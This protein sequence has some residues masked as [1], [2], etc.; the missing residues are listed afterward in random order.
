MGARTETESAP[1]VFS[2]A[3]EPSPWKTPPASPVDVCTDEKLYSGRWDWCGVKARTDVHIDNEKAKAMVEKLADFELQDACD[4]AFALGKQEIETLKHGLVM[5]RVRPHPEVVDTLMQHSFESGELRYDGI[6][7][8]GETSAGG[9]DTLESARKHIFEN[10][11][12]CMETA[13]MSTPEAKALAK[14]IIEEKKNVGYG[15][16]GQYY[17]QS[18]ALVKRTLIDPPVDETDTQTRA[19]GKFRASLEEHI[20]KFERADLK[21]MSKIGHIAESLDTQASL[22][23]KVIALSEKGKSLA[24]QMTKNSNEMTQVANQMHQATLQTRELHDLETEEQTTMRLQVAAMPLK[25]VR[26]ILNENRLKSWGKPD[27]LR[28]TLLRHYRGTIVDEF[29]LPESADGQPEPPLP[30]DIGNT[31]QAEAAEDEEQRQIA[32]HDAVE[33]RE[34][35]QAAALADQTVM[36]ATVHRVTVD[37][38]EKEAQR[39]AKKEAK[40]AAAKE[41]KEAKAAAAK[42][43]KEDKAAAAKAAKEAKAIA[44][45]AYMDAMAVIKG[46]GASGSN[47]SGNSTAAAEAPPEKKARIAEEEDEAAP[48]NEESAEEEAA[49]K[50][51]AEAATLDG[52][53]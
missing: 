26:V 40:A 15:K 16:A 6:S 17:R 45:Q 30:A 23:G 37:K 12:R 42:A 33:R 48:I 13:Q 41:A 8:A 20:A 7:F 38:A 52:H 11:A 28:D 36:D 22:A 31:T 19:I 14:T 3:E 25:E 34:D 27:L 9:I 46:R 49:T 47:N 10:M 5:C 4:W 53:K 1:E 21:C 43:A 29:R 24:V 51:E 50:A 32:I 44:R 39:K 2:D 35:A 18:I